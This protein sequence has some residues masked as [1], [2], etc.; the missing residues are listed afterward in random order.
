MGT[1]LNAGRPLYASVKW[2]DDASL[3]ESRRPCRGRGPQRPGSAQTQFSFVNQPHAGSWAWQG[4]EHPRSG[5][6]KGMLAG[7]SSTF[8]AFS[9][10]ARPG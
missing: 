10:L 7:S 9:G 5:L 4:D 8:G 6:N 1:K 3:R 2:G